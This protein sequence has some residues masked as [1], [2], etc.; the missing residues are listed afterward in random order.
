ME[1]EK[2][3]KIK[4]FLAKQPIKLAYLYGS[5]AEGKASEDSDI[6]IGVVLQNKAE[7]SIFRIGTELSQILPAEEFDVR[8]L[9]EDCNPVFGM[10]VI[11][12]AQVLYSRNEKER[13]DFELKIMDRYYDSKKIRRINYQ[14]LTDSAKKGRYGYSV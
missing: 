9:T 5:H 12:N 8:E 3:N 7:K 13:I 14:Y 6:D 10:N 1:K 4:Q 2:L 11:N